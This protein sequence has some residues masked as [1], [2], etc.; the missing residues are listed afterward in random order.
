MGSSTGDGSCTLK[1][2]NKYEARISKYDLSA[3]ALAKVETKSKQSGDVMETADKYY[4]F[5][6]QPVFWF[7][8]PKREKQMR[9]LSIEIRS[10]RRSLGEEGNEF[11]P[12]ES[13]IETV[14]ETDKK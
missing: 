10:E 8:Y 5:G 12:A 14:K 6:F 13:W 7:E 11:K 4:G 9:K 3:V 2:K 1:A